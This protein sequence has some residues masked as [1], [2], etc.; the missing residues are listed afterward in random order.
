FHDY[1]NASLGYTTESQWATQVANAAGVC[2][3]RT[4]VTEFGSPTT[5][6]LDYQNS[7][8][9]NTDYIPFLRGVTTEFRALPRASV[10]FPAHQN[11]LNTKRMFN[12]I[13]GDIFNR[14][15]LNRVQYGWNF[16]TPTEAPPCDF[17]TIGTS[18]YSIFR[19]SNQGWYIYP[20]INP[21]QYGAST[22]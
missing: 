15:A 9:G 17:N 8:P 5:T 4:I 1:Y 2:A 19:P 14:S 13:G 12:G 6:G 21:T 18:A 16:F 10:W 20:S 3:N 7:S 11:L 22:D